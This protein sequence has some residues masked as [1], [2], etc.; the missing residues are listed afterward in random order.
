MHA[1]YVLKN[2]KRF[3]VFLLLISLLATEPEDDED[4]DDEMDSDDD[5]PKLKWFEKVKEFFSDF[6]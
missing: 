3:L 6:F 1:T 2:K 5:E 4:F